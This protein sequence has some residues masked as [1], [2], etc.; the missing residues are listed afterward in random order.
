M[1]CSTIHESNNERGHW[2]L[3][4]EFVNDVDLEIVIHTPL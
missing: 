4:E 2:K 1:F 3:V